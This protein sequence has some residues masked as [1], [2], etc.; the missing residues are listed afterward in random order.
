MKT[1]WQYNFPGN[2]YFGENSLDELK[3]IYAASDK[4]K[5]L[6]I[7][8]QGIKNSGVL[9][10]LKEKL[11]V[12]DIPY[13]IF[14]QAKPEPTVKDVEEVLGTYKNKEI[15]ILIG[16]GGG[17]CIDLAKMIAFM[18]KTEQPISY[19]YNNKID[20]E[21][22]TIIAI[23]TTA[24]TGSEVT[25][26]AVVNDEE[27]NLKVGISSNFLKPKYAILD[28]Q[29][30]VG[31]PPRVTACSGI[32]ALVHAV[33]AYT[34]KN[35]NQF[36]TDYQADFRGSSILTNLFAEKAIRLITASLVDAFK[37]GKDIQAR[38]NMLLGSLLAGLAFSNAGT[39]ISH[40]M[41]Y[42]IGGRVHS[43]HGEITGLMLPYTVKYN[44]QSNEEKFDKLYDLCLP[45][46]KFSNQEEK[47]NQLFDYFIELLKSINLPTKLSEL[48]VD[49][50]DLK[51]MTM[52]TLDISRLMN[53][54]PR[55]A[56]EVTLFE[57]F[58]AAY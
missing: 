43:P 11:D 21:T 25:G 41:A 57:V 40:A 53:I 58:Q 36:D 12:F 49:E 20:F 47:E 16:L 7:T 2:I 26:V 1:Y 46:Q 15:D 8:D 18:L 52:E 51:A 4:P 5:T 23:P 6:V 42:A 14:D 3:N 28:P 17:S 13:E 34:S 9:N 24:G 38:S 19:F 35:F 29:L 22:T 32:D 30:T 54:N 48:H 31:M 55:L 10:V 50:R 45:G 44:Y 33:E 56:T 27:R 39:S 37:D